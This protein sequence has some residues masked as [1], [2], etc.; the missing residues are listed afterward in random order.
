M[1]WRQSLKGTKQ[2]AVE[3]NKRWET[4]AA[5]CKEVT[6]K[7][8]EIPMVEIIP[9]KTSKAVL[10][11]L[12]RFYAKLR[13]WGLP[14]YRL[15]SDCAREYTQESLRQWRPPCR[16]IRQAMVELNASLVE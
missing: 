6:H 11:A 12:N 2:R 8:V 1:W 15:H 7:V 13:A 3:D 14:V 10:S 16:N 5:A 9:A 4:I